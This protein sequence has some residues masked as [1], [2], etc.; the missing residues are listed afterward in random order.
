METN[1]WSSTVFVDMARITKAAQK[2]ETLVTASPSVHVKDPKHICNA[3]RAK[4]LCFNRKL[5]M[6]HELEQKTNNNDHK[7]NDNANY[8]LTEK[9]IAST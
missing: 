9:C 7:D 3:G 1:S 5:Q 4:L 6:E 2:E 8:E